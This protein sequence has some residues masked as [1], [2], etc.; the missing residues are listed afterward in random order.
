[1]PVRCEVCL[2]PGPSGA[3]SICPR[4][5]WDAASPWAEDPAER[6]AARAAFTARR[7]TRGVEGRG[8]RVLPWIVVAIA[9][10]GIAFVLLGW[11]AIL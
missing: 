7:E 1:M 6:M 3:G 9:V 5:G 10:A 11:R 8:D 2:G 4:C